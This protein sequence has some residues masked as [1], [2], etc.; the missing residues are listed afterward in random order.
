[1]IACDVQQPPAY[2]SNHA[3]VMHIS[4][5]ATAADLLPN[6]P[7]YMATTVEGSSAKSNL[8]PTSLR[9]RISV[10][11]E[12]SENSSKRPQRYNA[13]QAA[14]N[15]TQQLTM[16][17]PGKSPGKS[18]RQMEILR[19]RSEATRGRPRGARNAGAGRGAASRST[20]SSRGRGRGRAA[21]IVPMPVMY[22][23]ARMVSWPILLFS[24]FFS[25]FNSNPFNSCVFLRSFCAFSK[26][27]Q[28][29]AAGTIQD[30][31]QGTVYDFDNDEDSASSVGDLK[32]MR[33]R[34][35]SLELR[36]NPP[37][38]YRPQDTTET[39]KFAT[40]NNHKLSRMVYGSEV[41]DIQPPPVSPNRTNNMA[42]AQS[43]PLAANQPPIHIDSSIPVD[44]RTYGTAEPN[45]PQPIHPHK[46]RMTYDYQQQSYTK[47]AVS[48]YSMAVQDPDEPT[49]RDYA[50]PL[51]G[52]SSK[53]VPNTGTDD[54][55]NAHSWRK[56]HLNRYLNIKFFFIH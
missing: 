35:R 17:S 33:D 19:Q 2:N 5:T 46:L 15:I 50:A 20:S 13:Q 28:S 38:S 52:N 30:K 1:M 24:L 32:S 36:Q 51:K 56:S 6:I 41:R 53:A 31:L 29:M 27:K 11:P 37:E 16:K 25:S 9:M 8:S 34:G 43:L 44:M 54:Y 7:R 26:I 49:N 22:D 48:A 42:I 18:P 12:P 23:F 10:T 14:Q 3:K 55:M 47:V 21:H 40:A 45:A 4:E 39:L